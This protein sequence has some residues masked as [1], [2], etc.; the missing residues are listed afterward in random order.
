MAV[1]TGILAVDALGAVDVIHK[2]TCR[3]VVVVN[4]IGALAVAYTFTGLYPQ[5][6]NGTVDADYEGTV[7]E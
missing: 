1:V 5:H 2:K 7:S 3:G 6:S 4:A